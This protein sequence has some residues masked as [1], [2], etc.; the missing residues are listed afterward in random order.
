MTF[1]NYHLVLVI[2]YIAMKVE[3]P[4]EIKFIYDLAGMQ[5]LTFNYIPS[6]LVP[7]LIK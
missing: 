4:K 2:N 3:I 7:L 6:I 1:N 5:T